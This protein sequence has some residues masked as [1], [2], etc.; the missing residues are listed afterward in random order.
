MAET[1][2]TTAAPFEGAGTLLEVSPL[3]GSA[4]IAHFIAF[5]HHEVGAPEVDL[6]PHAGHEYAFQVAL[7]PERLIEAL[8]DSVDFRPQSLRSFSEGRL[9]VRLAGAEP[10]RIYATEGAPAAAARPQ[11]VAGAV[12]APPAPEV[13]QSEIVAAPEAEVAQPTDRS[14]AAPDTAQEAEPVALP[15]SEEH[16]LFEA[17]TRLSHVLDESLAEPAAEPAEQA[18]TVSSVAAEPAAVPAAPAEAIPAVDAPAQSS[19]PAMQST[20]TE[21]RSEDHRRDERSA[22]SAA[23]PPV[24]E[25]AQPAVPQGAPAESGVQLIARPFSNFGQLNRFITAIGALT[26]VRSVTLRRFRDGTLWLAVDCV[27]A[28]AFGARLR[29]QR[30]IPVEVVSEGDGTIEVTVREE[31]RQA[32]S[33]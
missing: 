9:Q 27:D 20:S 32:A 26:D 21:D 22:V 7:S 25:A 28:R 24:T 19:A 31:P 2:R 14:A 15:A 13:E 33:A 23:A 5:L 3:S 1:P 29:N 17:L 30:D 18:D 4:R 11:P 8:L 12:S 16:Q 6:A 10:A